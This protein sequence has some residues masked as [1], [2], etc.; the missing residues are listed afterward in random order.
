MKW[1]ISLFLRTEKNTGSEFSLKLEVLQDSASEINVVY[2]VN[3]QT[4]HLSIDLIF[5]VRR[6]CNLTF[7]VFNFQNSCF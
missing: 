1:S 6:S 7:K 2:E 3:F 4:V 5:P